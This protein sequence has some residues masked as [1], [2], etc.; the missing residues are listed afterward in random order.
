MKFILLTA[1]IITHLSAYSQENKQENKNP[2]N[3][4]ALMDTIW[5][6]EQIPIR[7]RDSLMRI[8]G[9]ESKE[10]K[11]QQL[12]YERNHMINEEKIKSLLNQ[13]G[14]PNEE[15]IG[16][17]GNW[18]ICNVLQHSD[19]EVRIEYLPLMRQAVKDGKLEPRFLARAEDR[20][21]TERGDLQIY[22]GQMKYYPETK[23]FNVWPVFDPANI[24]KR[25]A[26]IGLGPIKEFLKAR[27]DFD[28]NLEEQIERSKKFTENHN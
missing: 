28:W 19:N 8:H 25:R 15:M 26:E 6:A 5:L 18:T 23:S 10:Y 14:W 24:D 2:M 4:V 22:G 21:A 1:F 11:R 20:I 9:A 16:E 12:I 27:F 3:F 7:M 13:Y 17:R